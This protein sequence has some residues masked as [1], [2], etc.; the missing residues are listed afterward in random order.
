[1]F[2]LMSYGV[3]P[4]INENDPV[5]VDEIKFGDND[6]LAALTAGLI[7]ALADHAEGDDFA[8]AGGLFDGDR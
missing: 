8:G 7:E 6:M 5:A 3:I 4:L 1:M 2:T